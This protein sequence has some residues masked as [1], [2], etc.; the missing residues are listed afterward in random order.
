MWYPFLLLEL[1]WYLEIVDVV[2]LGH[3][4]ET[5]SKNKSVATQN[6]R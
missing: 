5:A 2:D 1:M 3:L 4:V 6:C